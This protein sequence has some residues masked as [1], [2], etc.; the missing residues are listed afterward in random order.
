MIIVRTQEG[1]IYSCVGIRKS[2]DGDFKIFGKVVGNNL[3]D[4][5][6]GEY[7][8]KNEVDSLLLTMFN[9]VKGLDNTFVMPKA[10]YIEDLKVKRR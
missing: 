10:G 2:K 7:K 6:L 9:V 1:D 3:T 8:S 4:Q 5:L